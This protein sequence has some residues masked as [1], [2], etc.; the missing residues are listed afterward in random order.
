[1]IGGVGLVVV[2]GYGLDVT[3]GSALRLTARKAD[4][5]GKVVALREV[6]E[7]NGAFVG[8]AAKIH[9]DGEVA[10][11]VNIVLDE[12]DEDFGCEGLEVV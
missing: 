9:N 6:P 1:M 8:V 2:V 10:T 3:G 7:A 12:G 11:A 4:E 5:E